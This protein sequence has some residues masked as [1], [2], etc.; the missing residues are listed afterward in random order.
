M[1]QAIQDQSVRGVN[2]QVKWFSCRI[3]HGPQSAFAERSQL[4]MWHKCM[5]AAD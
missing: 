4:M 1:N 3:R 2:F 5:A